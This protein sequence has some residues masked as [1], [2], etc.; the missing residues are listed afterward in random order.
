VGEGEGGGRYVICNIFH[1]I[2]QL[3]WS[4]RHFNSNGSKKFEVHKIKVFF[5]KNAAIALDRP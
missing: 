5:R 3:E 2:L 1:N 4:V